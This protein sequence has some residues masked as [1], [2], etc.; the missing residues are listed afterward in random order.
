MV[1]KKIY[2]VIIIFFLV[3]ISISFV[4]RDSPKNFT[5]N[6][7][8][9]DFSSINTLEKIKIEGKIRIGYAGYPPY[10]KKDPFTGEIS[11]FSVD[12]FKEIL[13]YWNRDIEIEWVETNWERNLFDLQNNRFDIMVEPVFR[14]I[15]RASEVAFTEPYSYFN[16]AIAVVPVGGKMFDNINELNDP[17]VTIAVGDGYASQKYADKNLPLAKKI[18]VSVSA[19]SPDNIFQQILFGKAD[20][21]LADELNAVGFA[22]THPEEVKV[23]FLDYPPAKTPAGF[24]I[25]QGDYEW[26]EFLDTSIEFLHASGDLERLS[27]EY[28]LHYFR[29]PIISS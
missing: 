16:Y 7:I 20:V 28:D 11:G 4:L 26:R 25:K 18:K 22:R 10:L 5:G 3:S 8:L 14:L 9:E 23:L 17:S 27:E 6:V 19:S 21:A 13:K 24:M 2:A 12:L 1:N 15:P 29:T